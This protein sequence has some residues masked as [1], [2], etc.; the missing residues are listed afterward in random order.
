VTKVDR[1]RSVMSRAGKLRS[2]LP[3]GKL[4]SIMSEVKR[5]MDGVFSE[6]R[7][8]ISSVMEDLIRECIS[9]WM[10][11]PSPD[12]VYQ[13]CKR[14]LSEITVGAPDKVAELEK[15][16]GNLRASSII[17]DVVKNIVV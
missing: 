14:L 6:I 11:P 3:K 13:A 15:E 2:V 7:N 4:K 5:H 9:S 8:V 10:E 16:L 1:L 17:N 12:E